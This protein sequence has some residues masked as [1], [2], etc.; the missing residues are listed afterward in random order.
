MKRSS[1]HPSGRETAGAIRPQ[2]AGSSGQRAFIPPG[3]NAPS[4]PELLR[5]LWLISHL[6]WIAEAT[7]R[8]SLMIAGPQAILATVVDGLR[9][10]LI[11]GWVE[12]R[13]TDAGA[14][15][16]EWRLTDSCRAALAVLGPLHLDLLGLNVD[17]RLVL[18]QTSR[19]SGPAVAGWRGRASP[20]PGSLRTAARGGQRRDLDRHADDRGSTAVFPVHTVERMTL[21]R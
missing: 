13:H 16:P 5:A 15:G 18:H 19:A 14:G 9:Q 6:C 8:R 12:E 10:L 20:A 1:I 21:R 4:D 17:G 11:G 2:R 3:R 7:I